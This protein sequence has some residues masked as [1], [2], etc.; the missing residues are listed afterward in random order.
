MLLGALYDRTLGAIRDAEAST[1]G[2]FDHIGFFE[3]A[4]LTGPLASARSAPRPHRRRQPRLR[5]HLYNESISP[6]PGTIEEGFANARTAADGYGTTFF[7]GE[8]GWFGD[9]AGDQPYLERYAA[10]EDDHLVGG[11]WWQWEAGVR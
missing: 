4:V 1:D 5:P 2:G 9:P 7:S 10:A 11:T 8:W 3:P 6:L